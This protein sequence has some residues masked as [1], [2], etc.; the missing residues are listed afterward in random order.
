LTRKGIEAAAKRHIDASGWM[1]D[2][3]TKAVGLHVADEVWETVDRHLFAD[4]SGRRR[5]SPRIGS[6]WDF[7]RIPG[8]ARSHTKA[9]PIWETYR[10]VGTLDGHLGAYR[11]PQLPAEITTGAAAAD[12]PAG[13]SILS[14]PARLP[15]PIRPA[16]GSWTAHDGALAVVFTARG[17]TTDLPTPYGRR[18]PPSKS[19]RAQSTGT[20]HQ[21][22]PMVLDRPGPAAT[23]RW[24]LL[25]KQHSAHP[26]TDQ[27]QS[28][29][30]AGPAEKN[31]PPSCSALHD[32]L[33]VNS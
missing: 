2:H 3:L 12:R 25:S 20:S 1:R 7:A 33:R 30:V 32:R 18:L 4:A 6:W 16:G 21:H 17:S 5:G 29:D 8:R 24:P 23:P 22:H 19:G 14:E 26:R 10:L 11:H 15:P 31:G 13:S 27:T 28:L 9:S